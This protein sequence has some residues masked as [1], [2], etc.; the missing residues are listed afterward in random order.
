[1]TEKKEPAQEDE[2]KIP[3]GCEVEMVVGNFSVILKSN[4]G[5]SLTQLIQQSIAVYE[6]VLMINNNSI[7]PGVQ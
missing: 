7:D 3:L 6:H 5:E 2:F 1:M 4:R